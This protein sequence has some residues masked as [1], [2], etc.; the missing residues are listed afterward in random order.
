MLSQVLKADLD[1]I[2]LTQGSTL[3]QYVDDL[4]L[5]TRTKQG[6]L[7]DSPVLLPA[8]AGRGHEAR[9]SKLQ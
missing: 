2:T 7:L 3:V 8:P 1:S 9:R 6:A 5:C 4:L